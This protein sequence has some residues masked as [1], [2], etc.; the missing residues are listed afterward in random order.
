MTC[1]TRPTCPTCPTS[2]P[3]PTSPTPPTFLTSPTCPTHSTCP[4]ENLVLDSPMQFSAFCDTS[5]LV[6]FREE[7]SCFV[8]TWWY[9]CEISLWYFERVWPLW[10]FLYD[11]LFALVPNMVVPTSRCFA[12]EMSSRDFHVFLGSLWGFLMRCRA[13][14]PPNCLFWCCAFLA[15]RRFGLVAWCLS[16]EECFACFGLSQ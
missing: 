8:A 13:F 7:I 11:R 1:P 10:G 3:F 5:F 4:Y 6:R 2:P 9:S 16:F 15:V 12:S 14:Q